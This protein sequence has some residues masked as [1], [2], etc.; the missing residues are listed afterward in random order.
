MRA[1]FRITVL[2]AFLAV[3]Q[4]ARRQ[5]VPIMRHR[6]L[7]CWWR[8]RYCRATHRAEALRS[9]AS[10]VFRRE[11][12]VGGNIGMAEA[13][14]AKGDGYTVLFAYKTWSIRACTSGS[15][16]TWKRI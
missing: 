12:G 13:A 2:L 14:H 16:L 9:P 6:A 3:A 5:A 11:R 15:R 4:T 1:V 10:A 7:P 8:H